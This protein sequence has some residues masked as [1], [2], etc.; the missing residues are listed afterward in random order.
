MKSKK[1]RLGRIIILKII[2]LTHCPLPTD[3]RSWKYV[4]NVDIR[5]H[6]VWMILCKLNINDIKYKTKSWVLVLL[7]LTGCRFLFSRWVCSM[8]F[9][10]RSPS[11]IFSVKKWNVFKHHAQTLEE[12]HLDIAEITDRSSSCL[13]WR[14]WGELWARQWVSGRTVIVVPGSIMICL[15]VYAIRPL[16]IREMLCKTNHYRQW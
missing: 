6:R 15:Q 9:K 4:S 16:V 3:I 14:G 10:S 1:A 7:T 13:G 11:S 2:L 12:H 5:G 8:D